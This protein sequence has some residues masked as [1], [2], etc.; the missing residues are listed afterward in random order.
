MGACRGPWALPPLFTPLALPGTHH[1]VDLVRVDRVIG[2][3][4]RPRHEQR[5]VRVLHAQRLDLAVK[6]AL[7]RRAAAAAVAASDDAGEGVG[8]DGLGSALPAHPP[9]WMPSQMEKAHGRRM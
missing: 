4:R 9:T 8:V 1:A 6:E 3:Q 7:H 2:L 5:E